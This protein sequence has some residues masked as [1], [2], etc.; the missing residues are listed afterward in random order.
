MFIWSFGYLLTLVKINWLDNIP[1]VCL[2]TML[3]DK[4][5]K[6]KCIVRLMLSLYR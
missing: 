6:E 4:E 5:E 2:I 1:Q 3:K